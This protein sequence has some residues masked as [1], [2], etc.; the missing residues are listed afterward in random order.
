MSKQRCQLF[1]M[2]SCRALTNLNLADCSKIWRRMQIL[3]IN[4]LLEIICIAELI[5][6]IL[7]WRSEIQLSCLTCGRT[8]HNTVK[9]IFYISLHYVF[10]FFRLFIFHSSFTVR[11]FQCIR[12][13]RSLPVTSHC[14]IRQQMH[15]FQN[16]RNRLFHSLLNLSQLTRAAWLGPTLIVCVNANLYVCMDVQA[17]VCVCLYVHTFV[18]DT[19]SNHRK[20]PGINLG[21]HTW[22]DHIICVCTHMLYGHIS[23]YFNRIAAE[24]TQRY[25]RIHT[26]TGRYVCACVCVWIN[27]I[28]VNLAPIKNDFESDSV[29]KTINAFVQAKITVGNKVEVAFIMPYSFL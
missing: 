11:Q 10:S 17:C 5:L 21:K 22:N 13:S 7:K 18:R 19:E 24:W 16:I 29:Q 26:H 25:P 2:N 8:W 4:N 9:Y 1:R 6:V 28:V 14:S 3:P 27:I 23:V 20:K 12:Y 15:H